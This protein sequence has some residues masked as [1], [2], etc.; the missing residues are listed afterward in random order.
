MYEL[1]QINNQSCFYFICSMKE[2]I[3]NTAN[4]AYK[5]QIIDFKIKN[6]EIKPKEI[7]Q[8]QENQIII[9]N[10]INQEYMLLIGK[11]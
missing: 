7:I 9:K 8:N 5:F 10:V 2:I 6:P 1:K 11:V 4:I 3:E